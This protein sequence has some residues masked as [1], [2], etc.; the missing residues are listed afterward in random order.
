MTVK[1]KNRARRSKLH[2]VCKTV[3]ARKAEIGKPE[4]LADF[5]RKLAAKSAVGK[6]TPKGKKKPRRNGTKNDLL[7]RW[8]RLKG[9][10]WTGENQK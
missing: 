8:R 3:D 4:L 6:V 5:R 2:D 7:D 10:G 1:S 9:S